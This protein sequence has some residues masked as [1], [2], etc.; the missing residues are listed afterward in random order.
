MEVS[1]CCSIY[2]SKFSSVRITKFK[3]RFLLFSVVFSGGAS[4]LT[5]VS[6]GSYPTSLLYLS[7]FLGWSSFLAMSTAIRSPELTRKREPLA[8][9]ALVSLVERTQAVQVVLMSA[10][11]ERNQSWC[12]QLLATH[13]CIAAVLT[14]LRDVV[15]RPHRNFPPFLHDKLF[16]Q[17]IANRPVTLLIVKSK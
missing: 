5:W 12:D 9:H 17:R 3:L 16:V 7:K 4:S 14:R 15:D 10:R 11:G 13:Q 2:I 6:F 1:L 8:P